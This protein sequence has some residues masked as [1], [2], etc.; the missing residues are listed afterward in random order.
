MFFVAAFCMVLFSCGTMSVQVLPSYIAEGREGK[1][2]G[3]KDLVFKLIWLIFAWIEECSYEQPGWLDV[4]S[5]CGTFRAA[6]QLQKDVSGVP[7]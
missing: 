4:M 6:L 2:R 7:R 3:C 1:G 5:S